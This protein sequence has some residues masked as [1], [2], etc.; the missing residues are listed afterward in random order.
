[1]VMG[2]D[3]NLPAMGMAAQELVLLHE[4]IQVL[5]LNI[6]FAMKASEGAAL[7]TKKRDGHGG[8]GETA[9]L[10]LSHP[11]LVYLERVRPDPDID[12]PPPREIVGGTPPLLGGG[13]YNPARDMAMYQY[14]RHPGQTGD[15][16]TATREVGQKSLEAMGAWTA[17][18]IKRDFFGK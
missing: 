13:V 1:L 15:P 4:D 7:K 8:A 12:A 9:R 6:M 11:N 16:T 3:E 17:D 5:S 18:V 2:H 10:M 14:G